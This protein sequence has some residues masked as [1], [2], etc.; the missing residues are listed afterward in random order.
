VTGGEVLARFLPD[1]PQPQPPVAL[2]V[3]WP[4]AEYRAMIT[5][6]SGLTAL[7][8]ATWDECRGRTERYC[9]LVDGNG[10][11]T[12][13][14]PGDAGGFEAFLA[15]RGVAEPSE[16]DLVAYPDLRTVDASAMTWWPPQRNGLCWCRSGAK[17]KRC[18]RPRGSDAS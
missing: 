12:R 3:F 2:A 16:D 17:Y 9:V 7:L 8:G 10:F 11:R 5:Q 15:A 1:G 4:E 6:R 18:C 14:L 13:Q